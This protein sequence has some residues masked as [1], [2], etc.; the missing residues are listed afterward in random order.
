MHGMV[1]Q[2]VFLPFVAAFSCADKCEGRQLGR[3]H[4]QGGGRAR[5]VPRPDEEDATRACAGGCEA[6]SDAGPE[7]EEDVSQ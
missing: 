2:F 1:N 6:A 7:A 3:A 5:E 4:P